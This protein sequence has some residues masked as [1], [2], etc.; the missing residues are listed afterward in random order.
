MVWGVSVDMTILH[1]FLSTPA[2]PACTD[3]LYSKEIERDV[4]TIAMTK[5][6]LRLKTLASFLHRTC[7]RPK[8]VRIRAVMC[9]P[10]VKCSCSELTLAKHLHTFFVLTKTEEIPVLSSIWLRFSSQSKAF[11]NIA[12][13]LFSKVNH[14]YME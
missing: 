6:I 8:P 12:F 11:F 4:T 13:G 5:A 10:C 2:C 3:M 7:L 1:T 14:I 9:I